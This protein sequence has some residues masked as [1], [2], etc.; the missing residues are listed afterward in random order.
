MAVNYYNRGQY[1][2]KYGNT[3]AMPPRLR[4][5]STSWDDNKKLIR[6]WDSERELF[7][8]RRSERTRTTAHNKVHFAYGKHT[9]SQLPN[10]TITI[11]HCEA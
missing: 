3:S 5:V 10:E 7:M 8:R 1:I 9:C 11:I 4:P 6:R 2:N